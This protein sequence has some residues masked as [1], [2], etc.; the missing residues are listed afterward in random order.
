[1]IFG[2]K[3]EELGGFEPYDLYDKLKELSFDTLFVGHY[4]NNNLSMDCDGLRISYGVKSS[5]HD[6]HKKLGSLLFSIND[7]EYKIEHKFID[8]LK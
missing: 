5:S 1:M 8:E 6:Y 2:E 4:H 3:G 7:K